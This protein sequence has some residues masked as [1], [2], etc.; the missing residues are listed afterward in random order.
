VLYYAGFDDTDWICASGLEGFSVGRFGGQRQR[1]TRGGI[2]EEQKSCSCAEELVGDD[3]VVLRRRL[4]VC[5][6]ACL[7]GIMVVNDLSSNRSKNVAT[8]NGQR[9]VGWCYWRSRLFDV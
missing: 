7:A 4:S 1:K 6:L 9:L 3:H 5:L 8:L 2:A